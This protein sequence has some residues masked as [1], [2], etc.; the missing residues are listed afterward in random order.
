MRRCRMGRGLCWAGGSMWSIL[1][2]MWN[3]CSK[4]RWCC[5]TPP[6]CSLPLSVS[7]FLTDHISVSFGGPSSPGRG[8]VSSPTDCTTCGGLGTTT[9]IDIASCNAG[10][11]CTRTQQQ[12]SF[13]SSQTY[14]LPLSAALSLAIASSFWHFSVTDVPMGRCD[15]TAQK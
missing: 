2:Q 12:A 1:T 10:Y 13:L 7:I 3:T 6:C 4:A 14:S 8:H 15:L 11:M 5:I 9:H